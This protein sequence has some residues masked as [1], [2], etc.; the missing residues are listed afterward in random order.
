MNEDDKPLVAGRSPSSWGADDLAPIAAGN[1]TLA[2]PPGWNE[3]HHYKNP[4]RKKLQ[5]CFYWTKNASDTNAPLYAAMAKKLLLEHNLTLDVCGG[6]AKTAERTL[7]FNDLVNTAFET[8]V[9]DQAQK[10][11]SHENHLPVV[12]CSFAAQAGH[13]SD[14][15]GYVTRLENGRTMVLINA[16]RTSSDHV[17]LMHE[18]GHVASGPTHV[19]AKPEHPVVNIMHTPPGDRP[20]TDILRQQV[21][22]LAKLP[23]AVDTK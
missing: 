10:L 11:H 23:Y 16:D 12:F 14:T 22:D 3:Q 7:A 15:N 19:F 17:T 18:L 8:D 13:D 9:W 5:C 20:R 1:Q 4:K 6:T 21:I 2:T